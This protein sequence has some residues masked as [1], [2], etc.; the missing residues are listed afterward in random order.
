MISLCV[1]TCILKE[2]MNNTETTP[3][4][5]PKLLNPATYA[6]NDVNSFNMQK[7]VSRVKLIFLSIQNWS[8]EVTIC[9]TH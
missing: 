2:Y 5:L 7:R 9:K 6:K 4:L 3:Q 1:S 8:E